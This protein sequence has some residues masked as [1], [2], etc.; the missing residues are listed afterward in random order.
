VRFA[1][2]LVVSSIGVLSHE[3][4]I[5][6]VVSF[7]NLAMHLALIVV[8]NLATRL[9]KHRLNRQQVSIRCGLKI[10]R[11]GLMSGTRSPSKMNPGA[12]SVAVK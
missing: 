6:G 1:K 12:S 9:R 7:K 5:Y 2:P 3:R 4:I 11:C 10:P 8:P